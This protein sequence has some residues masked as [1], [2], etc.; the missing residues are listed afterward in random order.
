MAHHHGYWSK[1]GL[2][3]VRQFCSA[4]VSRIH[5]DEY[6]AGT[7]ELQFRILEYQS[8]LLRMNGTLDSQDLLCDNRQNFQIDAIKFVETRPRTCASQSL[9]IFIILFEIKNKIV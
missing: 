8:L 9:E 1:Q 7:I 5:R 6:R 4:G 3:I 2:E